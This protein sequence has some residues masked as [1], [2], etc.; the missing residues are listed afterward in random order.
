MK[1]A[2]DIRGLNGIQLGDR[3]LIV[4]DVDEVALEFIT[5]FN[6]FLKSHGQELLPRSFRLTGNIVSLASGLETPADDVRTLLD[7]FFA[8]QMEWQ[9]PA[10][11]AATS[12]SALAGIA[13]ILFLTAMPTRHYDVRRALLDRHDLPFPLIATERSKGPLIGELH[14]DRPH[15]LFFIDDL[16]HNLHSVKQHA[17]A[18]NLLHYM[19]NE[20]FRAMAPHAGDDVK[21]ASDWGEIENIVKNHV[22]SGQPDISA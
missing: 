11:R 12:L 1:E 15:P 16:A 9:T 18:A 10:D 20:T 21:V 6:A 22:A 4:C 13:D 7:S 17:P 19:A 5:P 2:S 3:P 14:D 8:G